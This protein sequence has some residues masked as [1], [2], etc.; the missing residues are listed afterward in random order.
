MNSKLSFSE[1]VIPIIKHLFHEGIIDKKSADK[2]IRNSKLI[3]MSSVHPYI[4]ISDYNLKSLKTGKPISIEFITHFV[5]KI[6]N[7]G[8]LKIDPTKVNVSSV[9]SAVSQAYATKHKILPVDISDT[10]V[11]F[12]VAN[13]YDDSWVEELQ[14]ILRLKVIRVHS[15]PL[16]IQR[17][18][19]EFYGVNKSIKHAH[20]QHKNRTID[21]ILNLEQLVKLGSKNDLSADD[22]HIINIV[23]WLLHYA[24]EQ[25]ASDIHLEPK[26]ENS[27]MRFRIDGRLHNVYVLPTMVM[28]AVVSRIKILSRMDVAEKRKPQDGRIKTLTS[29]SKEVELR[30]STMPTTFGEKCVMRI[31]DPDAV[32]EKYQDLGMSDSEIDQWL[33]MISRPNG[34]VLVTGPTG[35]GK[36]TTL[37]STLKNLATEDVNVSSVEDPIEMVF[38]A[39]NQ[40][41]VNSKIGVNFSSGIRTLMRQD[42][43]IIMVGEIRDLETAQMAVQASLTGHLVLST[44]H[45]ND[46][47]SAI[48]RLLDLGVPDYLLRSTL[49]GVT[50]QRLVKLLCEH[51]KEE[52]T[53]SDE[54]WTS[55][56]HPWNIAKPE[57]IYEKN[58]CLE[59]RNTGYHGRIGVFEIMPIHADLRGM[60]KNSI[61]SEA[62]AE[63][64]YKSGMKPLR[65][66]LSALIKSGKTSVE[67]A[68]K[69]AP[70]EYS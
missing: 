20:K 2:I 53:V 29:E 68:I 34:I 37:Y 39:L 30:V 21:S 65:V 31:F 38:P 14:R 51:C 48:N 11:T 6:N 3:K 54:V 41:Q 69:L 24:F 52:T 22:Q 58:G 49:T 1:I 62:V 61:P 15:N 7:L 13:P 18:L 33:Q 8:Y 70:P 50:A 5:A 45:T 10:T 59:C 28:A 25:R 4:N 60:I 63:Q 17:L 67:E 56:T 16:D 19:F 35:S 57:T 47:P 26:R 46:A 64:A 9:T 12:A 36:T 42:P 32:V 43:D 23:D 40:M 44:L 27:I 66:S 55:L